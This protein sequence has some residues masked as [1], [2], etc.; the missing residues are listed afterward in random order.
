MS[1]PPKPPRRVRDYYLKVAKA[2]RTEFGP[3]DEPVGQCCGVYVLYDYEGEPIYVGHTT[4]TLAERIGRH[5]RSRRSDA[6][7]NS[8]LDPLEVVTI[9]MWPFWDLNKWKK[10]PKGKAKDAEKKRVENLL[11]QAE[12]TVLQR[13]LRGSQYKAVLNEAPIQPTKKLK[14]P[15]SCKVSIRVGDS[16][17]DEETD[18]AHPDV[19]LARRAR[20]FARL[21]QIIS[22]RQVKQGIRHTLLAQVR[23]LA[24]LAEQRVAATE[25]DK[26]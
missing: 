15:K 4:G 18:D 3:N 16:V 24:G 1:V 17:S 8:V 25:D 13:V 5:L 7:A 19:R 12:Y 11:K 20:T 10:R 2:L 22:E 6:V 21:A 26:D 9:E 23:R 14:L